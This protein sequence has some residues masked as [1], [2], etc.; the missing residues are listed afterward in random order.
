MTQRFI[1]EKVDIN[2]IS[3]VARKNDKGRKAAVDIMTIS[4]AECLTAR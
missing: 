2:S 3:G 1:T 4:F